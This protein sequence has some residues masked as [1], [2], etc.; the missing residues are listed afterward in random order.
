MPSTGRLAAAL[1]VAVLAIAAV[2]SG[3]AVWK[4]ISYTTTPRQPAISI[5]PAAYG[6]TF[7]SVTFP[8]ADATALTLRGWWIPNPHASRAVVLVHGRYQNRAD[9]LPIA[10]ALWGRGFNVLLFDLRGHGESAPAPC[11]YGLREQWDVIGAVEYVTSLGF[12]RNQ[13]GVI[14]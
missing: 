4:A 10:S 7:Q 14:G 13:I 2:Y 9:Y 12:T 5:S 1:L 11:S 8:S 6:L 3:L